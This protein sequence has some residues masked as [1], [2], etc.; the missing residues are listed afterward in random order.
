MIGKS[1]EFDGGFNYNYPLKNDSLIFKTVLRPT[2]IGLYSIMVISTN[3]N[4]NTNIN[5]E[6]ISDENCKEKYYGII[7]KINNGQINKNLVSH[8]DTFV[9]IMQKT[10]EQYFSENHSIFYIYVK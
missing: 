5:F 8:Y 7:S 1:T 9:P 3:S 6:K 10:K 4:R 2:K